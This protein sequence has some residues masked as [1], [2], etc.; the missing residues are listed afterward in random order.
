MAEET[1]LLQ[2]LEGIEARYEELATVIAD[3][4]VI[5]DRA[6]YARLTKEY[7]QTERI[8][9]ATKQYRSLL[10]AIAEAK[11]LLAS[12]DDSEMR[13]MAREELENAEKSFRRLRRR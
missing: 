7:S 4:E 12:E 10:S 13:E 11:E 6:R 1:S 2:R 8:V 5:A 3:P 9:N